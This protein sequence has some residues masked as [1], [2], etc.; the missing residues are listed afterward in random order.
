M[1]SKWLLVATAAMTVVALGARVCLLPIAADNGTGLSQANYPLLLILLGVTAVLLVMGR[2]PKKAV[3]SS[4]AAG[5]PSVA[6]GGAVGGA[7]ILLT[8]LYEAFR[9]LVQGVLPAP[10]MTAHSQIE[11]ILLAVTLLSGVVGGAF[12]LVRCVGAR[13][14]DAAQPLTCGA[15]LSRTA[16]MVVGTV[17][18]FSGFSVVLAAIRQFRETMGGRTSVS[19][20]QLAWMVLLLGLAGGVAL[21][22]GFVCWLR[23]GTYGTAWLWLALPVW[24]LARLTRYAVCYI[25]SP[26]VVPIVYEFLTFGTAAVFLLA[27]A[28]YMAAVGRA[29]P[30]VRGAGAAAVALSLAAVLGRVILWAMGE[31]AAAAYCPLGGLADV[32]VAVWALPL[33]RGLTVEP[34]DAAQ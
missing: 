34:N 6:L 29:T 17:G 16:A 28:R 24:M 33:V 30:W 20:R 27:A 14:K 5:Q 25:Q 8:S 15:T 18:V 26:D 10:V 23:R 13:G 21:V 7:L 31:T 32:G 22:A 12:L 1:R 2:V 9:W 3:L 11:E 4:S 19:A